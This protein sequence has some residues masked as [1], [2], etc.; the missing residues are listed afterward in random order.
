MGDLVIGFAK[1]VVEGAL[2]NAQSV[3]GQ[4]AKIRQCAQRD[5]T[6]I[7]GEFEM[8]QSFLNVANEER[9]KNIVVRTWVRQM[10]ELAFELEDVTE[11][12]RVNIDMAIWRHIRCLP[13]CMYPELSLVLDEAV[14]EIEQLKARVE[15]VSTRNARYG[16]ISDSGSKPVNL[17]GQQ[18]PA[19]C[20]AV[21]YDDTRREH[22]L[23]DLT[24]L[25]TKKDAAD[26]QVISVWG[27]GGGNGTT[28]I[29]RKSYS[30]PEI[31]HSFTC[32]AWVN[33]THPF[34]P[35]EFVRSLMAHF[36]ANSCQER[37]GAIIGIDVLTSMDASATQGDLLSEFVQLVDKN[38]Y[39]VVLEDLTTMAQW[40]SIRTFLPDRKN[41]SWIIVSSQQY[42]IASLCVEHPY[43]V[44]DLKQLP[45]ESSVCAFLREV[46]PRT[47]SVTLH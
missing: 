42:E 30:D 33:L 32:R 25:I 20:T 24:Q 41:G 10:R 5:L 18:Q 21:G 17:V 22:V 39:L 9:V 7:I 27:A 38:R 2:T 3:I 36:Y 40:D 15:D 14:D 11:L 31:N 43:Q 26:L 13:V 8:M 35:H 23:G 28:A 16:L 4:E 45:A 1:S 19:R 29:I 46:N 47:P 37:Q 34:S 12:V 44:L 6:F